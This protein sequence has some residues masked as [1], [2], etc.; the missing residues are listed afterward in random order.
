M[1]WEVGFLVD[2]YWGSMFRKKEISHLSYQIKMGPGA[3]AKI[4]FGQ[5]SSVSFKHRVF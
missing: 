3:M 1:R 2:G 5:A 4:F